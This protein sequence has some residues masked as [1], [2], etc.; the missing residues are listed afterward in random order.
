MWYLGYVPDAFTPLF[1]CF[2]VV[3]PGWFFKGIINA[4]IPLAPGPPVR[5]AA[6]Q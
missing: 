3:T 2:R 4:D 6:V 5:T 1:C